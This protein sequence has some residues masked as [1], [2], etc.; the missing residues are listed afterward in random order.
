MDGSDRGGVEEGKRS[1]GSSPSSG[2]HKKL[3]QTSSRELQF[4]CIL[5]TLLFDLA[6]KK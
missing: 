5:L 6:E 2:K 1:H 4:Q 3:K